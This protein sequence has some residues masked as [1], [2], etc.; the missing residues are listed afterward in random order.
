[1]KDQEIK[2]LQEDIRKM[3]NMNL[4]SINRNCFIKL[5]LRKGCLDTCSG[6]TAL[7]SLLSAFYPSEV[8]KMSIRNR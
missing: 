7:N 3:V 6:T 4:F 2:R 8:D 1:M 5:V